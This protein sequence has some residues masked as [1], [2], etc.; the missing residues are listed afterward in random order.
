MALKDSLRS[1]GQSL[2]ARARARFAPLVRLARRRPLPVALLAAIAVAALVG[3]AIAGG[4]GDEPAGPVPEASQG[5]APERISFLARLIPPAPERRSRRPSGP[6]VPRSV[7]DLARRLPTDRKVAQLFLLGFRGTDLTADIYEQLQRLDLGGVVIS[8]ANY[9]DAVLLGQ[10]AAEAVVV[11]RQSRRVPPLVMAQQEGGEFNSFPD[12]PPSLAPADLASAAEAAEEAAASASNL[13]QLNLTGV[14]GPVIDVGLS[15]DPALGARVYSDDPR[16]VASFAAA[17][18]RAYN[19]EGVLSSPGH[20]PGLGSGSASTEE[21]PSS[22][23]LTVDELAERDLVPFRAA[24][25]AGAPAV[26]LSSALYEPSDFTIPGVLD[27]AIATGLLRRRMRFRGVAITDDLADPA[28]TTFT[29]VADAAVQAIRAGADMLFV[30]GPPGDQRAAYVAVLRAAR[31]G[32]I[33]RRR[34]D[35]A[36]LRILAAK[37]RYGLIR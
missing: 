22:V 12:L 3:G 32:G 30:S 5:K 20:F 15:T 17:T 25:R 10:Q 2:R 37:R 31:R 34:L 19:E 28:I 23:G 21:A 4:G 26:I 35:E 29:S 9:T 1:F 7:A 18:V 14:L 33:T 16:E 8:A 11:S 24:F 13:R 27:R 6:N 36:V